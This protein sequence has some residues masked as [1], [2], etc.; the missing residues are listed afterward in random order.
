MLGCIFSHPVPF[1]LAPSWLN[2]WL[3]QFKYFEKHLLFTFTS[4]FKNTCSQEY[5]KHVLNLATGINLFHLLDGVGCVIELHRVLA[6]R[7]TLV[8]NS[9]DWTSPICDSS[10]KILLEI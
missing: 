3:F 4:N 10:S 6:T 9:N 5:P 8:A 2:S 1:L 7:S